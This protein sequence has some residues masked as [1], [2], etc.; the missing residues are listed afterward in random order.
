M[1]VCVLRDI[2][3][4]FHFQFLIFEDRICPVFTWPK[5][6]L[7]RLHLASIFAYLMCLGTCLLRIDLS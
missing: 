7:I 5:R 3:Q 2:F 1:S 4:L 6:P